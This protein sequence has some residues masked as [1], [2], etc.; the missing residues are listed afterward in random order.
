MSEVNLSCAYMSATK[1]LL[2]DRFR[3]TFLW[4][5]DVVTICDSDSFSESVPGKLPCDCSSIP[6]LSQNLDSNVPFLTLLMQS[7]ESCKKKCK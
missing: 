4:I 3:K 7:A 5:H 1:L 2:P 6:E